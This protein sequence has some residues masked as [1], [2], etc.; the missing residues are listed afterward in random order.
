M[1]YND[2]LDFFLSSFIWYFSIWKNKPT[3]GNALMNLRFRNERVVD[4]L[5]TL[6]H[7]ESA[8]SVF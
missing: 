6:E 7:R 3:P 5:L 2:E 1:K 8:I 4:N